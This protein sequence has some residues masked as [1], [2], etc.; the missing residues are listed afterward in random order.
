MSRVKKYLE[1]GRR[2]RSRL[3]IVLSLVVGAVLA[4]TT[5]VSV[6]YALPATVQG[7][8]PRGT[9]INLFDYWLSNNANNRYNN[10]QSSPDNYKDVGI[11]ANHTLKF[12]QGMGT[13]PI[14]ANLDTDT[15]NHWTGNFSNTQDNANEPAPRTGIVQSELGP[16]GYPV[17]SDTLGS[18]S[19][20]YLFDSSS[21]NGKASYMNV[22]GLLQVD[23]DGYYYY[24]STENFAQFN[25]GSNSFTLYNTWGVNAGGQSP[26]GQFF[27]FNTGNDVFTNNSQRDITSTA[28]TIHHYF[29]LNMSTNFIQQYGGHTDENQR[30]DV[31]YNFSGDDDVWVYIDDVLVGDLGGIH[32]KVAL[33]INFDSGEVVVYS[34]GNNNNQFDTSQSQQD[35]TNMTA[36][37]IESALNSRR[38]VFYQRT[39]LK[40]L[41][42][43]AGVDTSSWTSDTLP[44]NTYHTLDFFYLERGNTDSNMSLKYNLVT[45]P[46]TDIQKVDQD[47]NG[48]AGAVF[49]VTDQNGSRVCTATTENDGSV[50]LM[51]EDRHPVTVDQLAAN[52]CTN[53][54]FTEASVPDG[55][56]SMGSF[57][58]YIDQLKPSDGGDGLNVLLSQN[59]WATGA[60]AEPRVM[61]ALPTSL[62]EAGSQYDTET[63]MFF[64]VVEKNVNGQWRPV[65]GNGRDGWNVADSNSNSAILEAGRTTNAVFVIASNGAYQAEIDALPGDI[66]DYQYFAGESATLRVAYYYVN[67]RSFST[68]AEAQEITDTTNFG[69]QF[70]AHLY[71]PNM[72]N[73]VAVQKLDEDGHPLTGAR[74][75]L[76]SDNQ[77]T[78]DQ[79]TGI[80]SLNEGAQPIRTADTENLTKAEDGITLEGGAVFTGVNPGTYYI[81]EISAPSG[82][83]VNK[84][85]TKVI[86]TNTGVYADAGVQD[87]GI[88]VTRGVGRIVQSMQQFAEND[89][90]D[91]SLA[92]II[93]QPLTL[94]EE[95]LSTVGQIT[96]DREAADLVHLR[97]AG[98]RSDANTLDYVP[99]DGASFSGYT[100]DEGIPYLTIAQDQ[101]SNH[102][103]QPRQTVDDNITN[104]FSG[105]TVVHVA[106]EPVGSL[107]VSKE[108]TG[109]TDS[110]TDFEFT[111]TF[112]WVAEGSDG[113]QEQRTALT[114]DEAQAVGMQLAIAGGD[115]ADVSLND[116]GGN[117]LQA[118]RWRIGGGDKHPRG[119]DLYRCRDSGFELRDNI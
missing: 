53:L 31:T 40:A 38:D 26:N 84:T 68:D 79:E 1:G 113:S 47:G 65:T 8:T 33:Q 16:D 97:Y 109:T 67:S 96:I 35:G 11:N 6:A 52:G 108:V 66:R 77:V 116:E 28:E 98:D 23:N 82:Y 107:E 72:V 18:E 87:D 20:A 111:V 50:V 42:N 27:P 60:Y 94:A 24:N 70:S 7:V 2:N 83:A 25:E 4:V 92:D 85:L 12:G 64:A 112:E 58:M 55:Y 75:G 93:A 43:A 13:S 106:D 34:D 101:D 32:D 39:T 86:V 30:Q 29:G 21:S 89:D 69:R 105:V 100:V 110:A 90:I 19:L 104:L 76:Y 48:V 46:E 117:H 22:G 49:N 9:T 99:Q 95:D 71:L 78:V 37:Q 115:P 59:P 118:E 57:T 91:A 114:A 54:T 3:G 88:T 56:R 5:Y 119:C 102:Q 10:D 36:S 45:I 41:F 73:R 44:D 14:S 17:L 63:G 51:D 61:V 103:T 62:T 15:V 74:F 80:A 81:G